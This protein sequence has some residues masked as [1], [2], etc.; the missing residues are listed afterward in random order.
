MRDRDR[1]SALTLAFREVTLCVIGLFEVYDADPE[2][3]SATADALGRV[4]RAHLN[5]PDSPRGETK[6]ALHR[7]L[8]DIDLAADAA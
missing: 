4:F 8:A 7:L 5:R 2:L 1:R 6:S 3:A